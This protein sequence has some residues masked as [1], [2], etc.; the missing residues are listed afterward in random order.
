MAFLDLQGTSTFTLIKRT[1]KNFISDD[2][3][4]Y[5]AALSYRAL[6]ALF[7]FLLFLIAMLS[8]LNLQDFFGWLREQAALVLPSAALEIVDPVITDLQSGKNSIFSVAIVVAIWVASNGIRSL[9]NAM[10]KAY[11]VSETRPGWKRYLLSVAYTVGLALLLLTATAL[12]V[13][14]PGLIAWIGSWVGLGDMAVTLWAVLRWP[15]AI[16]LLMLVVALLYYFTPDV[17]QKFRYITPGS[18]MAV[19]IWIVASLGFGFYV[20]NFG[21]YDAMYGGI[22]AMIVLLLFFYISSAVLLLGA[23]LNAT[24]EHASTEGKD[25][26]EKQVES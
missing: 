25:K 13:V 11:N 2:M 22:G 12:M 18:I 5:A 23:E 9:M 24:I 3:P 21:N 10:N 8:F 20:S 7:P 17:E 15:F 1:F 4:T 14:G 19:I 26:G 6:F 16:M